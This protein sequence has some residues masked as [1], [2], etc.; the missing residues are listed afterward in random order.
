MVGC[1]APCEMI[2]VLYLLDTCSSF[3]SYENQKGLPARPTLGHC[4]W[5]RKMVQ[6]LLK[7]VWKFLK[8]LK[9]ELAYDL[10]TPLLDIQPN[11]LKA[12]S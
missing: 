8:K 9:I 11:E 4:W 3:P 7:I 1:P 10:V 2:S 12:E 6:L 5:G